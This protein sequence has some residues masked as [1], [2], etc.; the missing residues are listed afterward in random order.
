MN[1]D[2]TFKQLTL[3]PGED[4]TVIAA[5]GS[6]IDVLADGTVARVQYSWAQHSNDIGDFCPW[7]GKPLSR[8]MT[9]GIM[10][11]CEDDITCP[12]LCR[13]A[14]VEEMETSA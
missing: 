12:Q 11:G 8:E 6:V 10:L 3:E 2:R 5:N 14:T 4:V 9:E 1:L 7:S 13:A